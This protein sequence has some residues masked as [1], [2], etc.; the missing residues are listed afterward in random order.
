M[1][2]I[3]VVCVKC[4]TTEA[5]EKNKNTTD[6]CKKCRGVEKRKQHYIT[7]PC[8]G[9]GKD[10]QVYKYNKPYRSL[11][12]SCAHV[13]NIVSDETRKKLSIATSGVNNPFFG[14]RHTTDAK[15]TIQRKGKERKAAGYF[16][17]T[18]FRS[19]TSLGTIQA[20]DRI[21]R[22]TGVRHKPV[23]EYWVEK[24]GK[25]IAD[26]KHTELRRKHSVNNSGS[27]N[28]MFLIL[29]LLTRFLL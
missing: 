29:I 24:Y 14:K 17:T 18:E 7:I 9:C 11:C 1:E 12:L 3:T 19:K 10:R 16:D 6:L 21:E 28:R 13:G 4:G 23:Y 22:E 2:N 26:T 15:K 25:E 5:F 27:K 20:F 8:E